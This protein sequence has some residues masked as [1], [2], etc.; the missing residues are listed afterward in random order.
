LKTRDF[1]VVSYLQSRNVR[2]DT[3][4]KNIAG[5]WIG[6]NCLFCIDPSN[7][8][9]INLQSKA[10]SCFKC[11]ETGSAV[12]L[13]QTIEGIQDVGEALSI[14]KKFGGGFYSP[15]ERQ[16]QSKVKLPIGASKKLD[17]CHISFLE[18]RRFPKEVIDKYDLYGVGPIGDFK[19]RVIIPIYMN[20]R[21]LG[22]VGRDVTGYAQIP[23]LNSSPESSIK[24][25]KHCLYNM[26]NVLRKTVVIVEGIF[27]AWRI[28]DGAVATLGV[29]YTHEQ[30]LL[31]R[32]M[33]KAFVLFD[34]DAITMAHSL[35]HDLSSIVPNVEVL[36]LETGDPD[37][38]SDEDVK[39]LRKDIKL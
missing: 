18:N 30:L 15:E 23:Y 31:L 17:E 39:S 22:F 34:A 3:S 21:M 4:G 16:Y 12:K 28:G 26:D 27:D 14:M 7:H 24:D 6:I 11:G 10:F 25:V 37:D 36:E 38:L 19:Y 9:G 32:G 5:G 2:V 13:I 1:D 35:A 20:N 29:K 33:K 8:L